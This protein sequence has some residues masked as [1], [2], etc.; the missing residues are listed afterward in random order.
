MSL[1]F[2][3]MLYSVTPEEALKNAQN[4]VGKASSI[5]ASF[6]MNMGGKNISGTIYTKGKKFSLV[7]NLS[8]CWYDGA[9]LWTY[10]PATSETMLTKPTASELAQ[11]NP[12][13][14]INNA[15][16]FK[17]V[18]SKT[19]KKGCETVVLIPKSTSMGV[20]SVILYINSSTWLPESME[21]TPGSGS[22]MTIQLSNI[23][24]NPSLS[25]NTFT[26]PKS[27]YPKVKIVDMR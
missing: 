7:S 13:L 27:K 5:S 24:L 8:S 9:N 4:K 3:T 15:S 17:V 2:P 26:Y 21:I 16:N 12:L 22:K 23:K 18:S 6:K 14:Y 25:D 19:V 11:S 20:K 10:N 1:L